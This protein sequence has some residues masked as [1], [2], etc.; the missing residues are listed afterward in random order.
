MALDAAQDVEAGNLGEFQ[1]EED[2]HRLGCALLPLREVAE[3][4]LTVPRDDERVDELAFGERP[5][6]QIDIHRVVF[7]QQDGA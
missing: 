4:F 1:V 7:H 2:D 6:R 5:L 3:G